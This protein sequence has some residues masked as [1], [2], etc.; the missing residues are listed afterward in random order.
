MS[1]VR[2]EGAFDDVFIS[3]LCFPGNRESWREKQKPA[4][5]SSGFQKNGVTINSFGNPA[6]AE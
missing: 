1:S 4:G 6:G 2:I 3:S 5:E